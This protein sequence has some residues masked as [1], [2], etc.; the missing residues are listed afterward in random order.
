MEKITGFDLSIL[1]IKLMCLM[2]CT[3]LSFQFLGNTVTSFWN[4]KL[5]FWSCFLGFEFLEFHVIQLGKII[6]F[7]FS[8][9]L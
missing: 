2:T 4:F 3:R 1:A 7:L 6:G 9:L 8:S 5:F